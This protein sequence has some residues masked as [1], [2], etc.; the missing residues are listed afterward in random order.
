LLILILFGLLALPARAQYGSASH[1]VTI[2][3]AEINQLQ[4]IGGAVSMTIDGAGV[5]AGQDQMTATNQLTSL[6]WGTN[7]GSRK[8]T[9]ATNLAA[10]LFALKLLAVNP[11][12]GT[13]APE[14]T[15]STLASDLLL[16]IGRS[17]GSCQL[18]YT[19]VAL[20]SQGMGTDSHT[21]TFTIQAQ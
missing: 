1:T 4:V 21:I 9:V 13:A 12:V 11:T 19:G 20:A 8:I 3:V 16:N 10:Q 5:P 7:A 14:V 2:T 6:G 18:R 15:L 17:L